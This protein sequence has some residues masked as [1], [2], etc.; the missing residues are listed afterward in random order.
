M[1]QYLYTFARGN[2]S[3]TKRFRVITAKTLK[4]PMEE[5]TNQFKEELLASISELFLKYGLRSTSMDDMATHLKIS[6]KTLYQQFTNKDD[7]VEQ[8]M[9]YRRRVRIKNA[10]TEGLDKLNPIEVISRIK[11]FM[12]SD[13]GSRI[14]ANYYDM[15]KYHPAVYQKIA[16]QDA[17]LTKNFLV[18]LLDSGIKKKYFKDDVDKDLQLYLL[19]K[20][21][22]FL[23]EPE[24]ISQIIYPL[25]VIVTTIFINFIY[26]ISTEKGIKE[27]E[28]LKEETKTTKN[29]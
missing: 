12:E 11:D 7:V 9:L 10:N 19:G 21:L 22:Q 14:P 15:K 18:T 24:V 17:A 16:E 13:L 29:V 28:R 1:D 27:F 3:P 5:N 2:E 23:R 20:Q 25:P 4:S 8:V 6:K 26:A